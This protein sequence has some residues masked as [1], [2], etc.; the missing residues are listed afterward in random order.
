MRVA[1]TG[2]SGNVGTALL[3]ALASE[4]AVDSIVGI[5]RRLPRASFPKVTWAAADV[6]HHDLTPHFAG[7]DCVVHLAWLIQPS[8][9]RNATWLAN[10]HGSRRVFG[11]V[12][13]AGVPALVYASSVGAYSPGPK[14]RLVDES[15]PTGGIPTSFYSRDKAEVERLLDRFE[16]DHP[17]VRSVRLR[18]SLVF[19]R[20]MG[21][22]AKR[23]FTGRWIPHRLLSPER[24]PF[25]PDLERLRFQVT[26]SDD[27]AD[28][29]RR[30]IVGDARGAFN[31]AAEPVVD[32]DLLA[33]L[34]G[35]RKVRV[36]EGLVRSV[37]AATWRARLQPTPEG[38]VDMGLQTP[39][40]DASRV[41]RE[42]GW[43]P[44]RR[45]DEA[46]LELLRGFH[47]GDGAPTPPLGR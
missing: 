37:V 33:G 12:A 40:M 20:S 36:P 39:L 2:A 18:T 34:L 19:Q 6:A 1:V 45:A 46:L 9:D 32:P 15:W 25:V 5:A 23:L 30:A 13:E 11:A 28:S 29:Y 35:A 4:P 3:R 27:V 38:W 17:S 41:R 22:E 8:H 42:L 26:H 14:D 16:G 44:V 7:V 10:V 43:E 31:V 24:V 21:I 47:A